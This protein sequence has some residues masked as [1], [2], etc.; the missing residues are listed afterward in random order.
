MPGPKSFES[1]GMD[2]RHD[3]L[4]CSITAPQKRLPK[5]SLLNSGKSPVSVC[6]DK[7]IKRTYLAFV[8]LDHTPTVNWLAFL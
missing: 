5:D 4:E 2:L 7:A 3:F 8:L 1:S 6:D